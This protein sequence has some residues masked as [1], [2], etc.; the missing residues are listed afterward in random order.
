MISDYAYARSAYG[1]LNCTDRNGIE[2]TL[3][4]YPRFGGRAE[5]ACVEGVIQWAI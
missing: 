4:A 2:T 3:Q 1:Q 5:F